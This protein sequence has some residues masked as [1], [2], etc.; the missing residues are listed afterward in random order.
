MTAQTARST[1]P[2]DDQP[3]DFNLDAV[4]AEVNLEPFRFNH[5]G[6]RFVM[7]N[8][9]ELDS[10][11]VV[12][13]AD[14]GD[15]KAMMDG[16]KLALGEQWEAF[17]AIPLKQWKLRALFTAYRKHCGLDEGESVASDGS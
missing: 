9:N 11:E 8:L 12:A 13:L 1:K 16:F 15:V 6:K 14:G 10:W 4:K 17:R 7:V 2:R 5:G 3:F